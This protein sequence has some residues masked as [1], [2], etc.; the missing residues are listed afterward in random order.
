[1]LFHL[2]DSRHGPL[3][4]D[5]IIMQLVKEVTVAA[6][7]LFFDETLAFCECLAAVH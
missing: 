6:E 2:M 5:L 1:M 3:E 7:R 4:Q